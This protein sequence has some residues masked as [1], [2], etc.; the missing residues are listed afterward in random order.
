MTTTELAEKIRPM[1]RWETSDAP[2]ALYCKAVFRAEWNVRIERLEIRHEPDCIERWKGR[3][4][5]KLAEYI[6]RITEAPSPDSDQL[7]AREIAEH[8]LISYGR[9]SSETKGGSSSAR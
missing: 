9:G 5:G 3:A 2:D 6:L 7:A 8:C 4:I 1:V